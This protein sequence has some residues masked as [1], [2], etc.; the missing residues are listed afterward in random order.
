MTNDTA[1]EQIEETI[2]D[3]YSALFVY[4]QA[5]GDRGI[6]ITP[7]EAVTDEDYEYEVVEQVG[8]AIEQSYTGTV[9]Q[10]GTEWVVEPDHDETPIRED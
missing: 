6:R 2:R 3:Y 8:D 4:A 9:V 1:E 10:E 7:L 5:N